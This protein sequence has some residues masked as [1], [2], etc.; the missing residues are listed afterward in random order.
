M[1]ELM[2]LGKVGVGIK[3]NLDYLG[4]TFRFRILFNKRILDSNLKKMLLN[5]HIKI[6]LRPNK[7][8]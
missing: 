8:F 5:E 6:T 3:S 2:V 4:R 7:I 1:I